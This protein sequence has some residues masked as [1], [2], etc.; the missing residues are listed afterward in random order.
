MKRLATRA[1]GTAAEAAGNAG[2]D[3]SKSTGRLIVV[4][5]RLPV[6]AVKTDGKYS[7]KMSS[8]GLVS[9][10]VSVRDKLKFVWLG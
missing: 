10:L 4:A 2:T 1:T 3:A 8:G 6:S 5:N 9:A 7:F